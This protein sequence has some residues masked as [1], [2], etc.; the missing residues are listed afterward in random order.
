MTT[1]PSAFCIAVCDPA[2]PIPRIESCLDV[3]PRL[4]DLI[5]LPPRSRVVVRYDANVP[6][7][8][9]G[10]IAD[11]SRLLCLLDTL[12]FGIARG[13]IVIALGH[14]GTSRYPSLRP[15]WARIRALVAERHL[16]ATD[17]LFLEEWLQDST[18]SL[19]EGLEALFASLSPA[20]IVVLENARRYSLERTFLNGTLSLSSSDRDRIAR[21]AEDSKVKLAD[22]F[23]QEAFASHN[24][25]LSSILLPFTVARTALGRHTHRELQ[26]LA[27]GP[28]RADMV[29][30]SGAKLQKLHDLLAIVRDSSV[31]TVVTGGLLGGVLAKAVSV[32]RG[33]Q[34]SLGRSESTVATGEEWFIAPH[35]HS[36]AGEI[37][38]VAS[39]RGIQV[40]TPTDFR[41]DDE[42]VGSSVP[43]DCIQ[44]D[45]GPVTLQMLS[46]QF[47]ELIRYH[48]HKSRLGLGSAVVYLNGVF[49]LFEREVFSIG[50]R[51]VINEL[52]R[53]HDAGVEV[54]VGGGEGALALRR[55]GS[56]ASV[57]HCFTAG[58]TVLKVL[59][60]KPIP[61]LAAICLAQ[62]AQSKPLA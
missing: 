18:G 14:A 22:A 1:D 28:G 35:W 49:G 29:I 48:Q 15:V 17:I 52:K 9:A 44:L 53:M 4:D 43:S 2:T 54:Y 36:V 60:N 26:L 55:Y 47:D 42:S 58:G 11:D 8:G 12:A 13:W 38:R 24:P 37:L 7:D 20:S 61:Y 31:R 40:H 33:Q 6:F 27:T 32:R 62:F 45:V 30:F 56:E 50:T 39:N 3:A 57:T 46:T 23:V 19:V 16:P 51:H 10:N 41:F 25:D 34:I 21:F 5:D 59:G